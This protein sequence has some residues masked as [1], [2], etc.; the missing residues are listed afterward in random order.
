[1]DL[2][3]PAPPPR[4]GASVAPGYAIAR[5]PFAGS[6][7]P[8]SVPTTW[9]TAVQARLQSLERGTR[10][11]TY[12]RWTAPLV[13]ERAVN[14]ALNAYGREIQAWLRNP[15]DRFPFTREFSV[16]FDVGRTVER[17]ELHRA[18]AQARLP[19]T[20]A[21]R[22][23]RIVLGIAPEGPGFIVSQAYPVP[24]LPGHGVEVSALE[25]YEAR[26]PHEAYTRGHTLQRH[27]AIEN[28]EIVDLEAGIA[29][30]MERLDREPR[31]A[32]AGRFDSHE[33]AEEVKRIM[34]AHW[35]RQIA[36]WK[37]Q[38]EV[39]GEPFVRELVFDNR[40]GWV[41]DRYEHDQAIRDNRAPLPEAARAARIVLRRSND[42][43]EGYYVV[44]LY[45]IV[46]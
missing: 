10:L 13:A 27:S 41:I 21:T 30:A 11:S 43:A 16:P 34:V 6:D 28:H 14:A 32:A 38:T 5:V 36:G 2:E 18:A 24:E 4:P 22:T 1:M 35:G 31:I 20:S 25:A 33:V 37:E 45:P 42:Y 9:E 12:S 19:V 26:G 15:Y 3:S 39:G 44:T 17:E 8:F 23:F 40:V 46:A 7:V 29:D